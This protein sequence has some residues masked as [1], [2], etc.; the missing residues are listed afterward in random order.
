[1]TTEVNKPKKIYIVIAVVFAIIG[2]VFFGLVF[3]KDKEPTAY[4]Q[5]KHASEQ[6]NDACPV[7]VDSLT[8]LVSTKVLSGLVMQY[9]YTLKP[10]ED[11]EIDNEVIKE[12]MKPQMIKKL[13]SLPQLDFYKKHKVAFK[14]RFSDPQ[15]VFLFEIS[16]SANEYGQENS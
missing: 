7:F 10:F 15:G 3:N 13:E 14:H 11:D 9:N 12:L 8:Q 2:H 6:I 4:E 1:M 16:I 5:L